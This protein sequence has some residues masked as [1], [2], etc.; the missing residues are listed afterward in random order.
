MD[1]SDSIL[2]DV[3]ITRKV[4][5]DKHIPAKVPQNSRKGEF[6]NSGKNSKDWR[7]KKIQGE[8]ISMRKGTA[9]VSW[10]AWEMQQDWKPHT[11][12]IHLVEKQKL[13]QHCKTIILQWKKRRKSRNRKYSWKG[14][15]QISALKSS[16]WA[17][18]K[19]AWT[20]RKITMDLSQTCPYSL[21]KRTSRSQTSCHQVTFFNGVSSFYVSYTESPCCG[22]H[23]VLRGQVSRH[24]PSLL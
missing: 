9:V 6:L 20:T 13:T 14:W 18:Q 16:W 2:N 5:D 15:V 12:P 11:Q 3:S 24:Q 7:K 21:W 10:Y 8:R 22:D 17:E 1:N 23:V 4:T 19:E